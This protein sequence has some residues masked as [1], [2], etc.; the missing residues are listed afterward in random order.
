MTHSIHK[1]LIEIFGERVAFHELE[2]QVYS[3]DAANL[4]TLLTTTLKTLPQAIVQPANANEL[5]LLLSLA[6]KEHIP[7]VPRGSGTAGYGGAVPTRGGIV[8]DFF[9]LNSILSVDEKNCSVT[10]E[11]GVIWQELENHLQAHG[12]ALRSYPTSAVSA[13]VGGWLAAGG[14]AG[15]GSYKFGNLANS[16]IELEL[17]TPSGICTLGQGDIRLVSGLCGATG[18]ISRV[19]LAVRKLTED[20]IL[21]AVFPHLESFL[22]VV[23]RSNDVSLPLWHVGYSSARHESLS[24]QALIC[25]IQRDEIHND[26]IDLPSSPD[27]TN[28]E[29]YGVFVGPPNAV[30]HL[31]KLIMSAGAKLLDQQATDHVWQERFYPL[32]QKALGPSIIP[33]EV[34]VHTV[35]LPALVKSAKKKLGD[36]FSLEGTL[37]EGGKEASALF[38]FLDDERRP[39]FSLA[40]SKSLALVSEAKKL[41]GKA[42]AIGMLLTLEAVDLW[43]K[44][45]LKQIYNFKKKVDPSS[46]MNPGKVFP[47]SIDR[48]SPVRMVEVLS[49]LAKTFD[50]LI[51]NTDRVL[52]RHYFGGD[53]YRQSI[54]KRRPSNDDIGWDALA[55]TSCGYCRTVCTEFHVVGWESASPRGKFT[56]LRNYIKGKAKLDERMADMFFMC[57]TCRRCDITCQARI[58]ILK[59]WDLSMRPTLWKQ[60]YNLP[61]FHRDTTENVIK[62]HNPMGHPHVKRTDFLA[63]DI[64]YLDEGETAYW[65]GCTA[66][67]ALKQLAENPLRILNAGGIEPVL[68]RADEWCCG[69]DIVLYGRMDDAMDTVRHNIE[70][71]HQRGVKRLMTHCPGCWAAFSLYYPTLAKKLNLHWDV[72]VEHITQTVANLIRAGRLELKHPMNLKVTYHDACHLGR[73]GGIYEPPRQILKAIPGVELVEM[74][75]NKANSP[76]CGRQLFQYTAEGSKPYVDRV[77]E[78]QDVGASVLVTNCPGCQVAYILGAR[79]IGIENLECLDITDLI[80][81]S[82]GIPVIPYKVIARMARQGYEQ[83]VKPK[84]KQDIARS[85]A[86]LAPHQ[87]KYKVLPGK[88]LG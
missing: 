77:A 57:A 14:G 47:A 5:Q 2:R 61:A 80:C 55:C 54:S 62:E 53:F 63:P 66:S 24:K 27:I 21:A 70:A 45:R 72:E 1:E 87:D 22:E 18:F 17:V 3:R 83:G 25:Q 19:T 58:P 13:T 29:I 73:R 85:S 20:K 10:T 51:R 36:H 64:R 76:C 8:V 39:G 12:L 79:E 34:I 67:Y 6:V 75:Q 31:T 23:Q 82:M 68:F 78:A 52:W 46:I 40:Y 84:I 11:P 16:I 15:I 59:H 26:R 4:P 86:L 32:R 43:G 28:E 9:R 69:S 37:I 33:G 88:R 56:F 49:K 60:G 48:R 71:I 74:P 42:Y 38:I 30:E 35:K 50:W 65:V 44:E 81:T 7:L 41:G